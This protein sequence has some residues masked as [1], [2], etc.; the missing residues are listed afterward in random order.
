M[1]VTI[2]DCVSVR[3]RARQ[4]G[5]SPPERIAVLPANFETA[6]SSAQLLYP[7]EA[8]TVKTLFRSNR[9]PLDNLMS[10]SESSRYIHNNDF[11][12]LAPT[13]FVSWGII[14]ENQTFVTV[15]LNVL[16][17]YITEFFRGIPGTR[18]VKFDIVVERNVEGI[19]RKISYQGTPEG[20]RSL[21]EV[22][23]KLCDE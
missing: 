8:A 7:S 12:W 21:P 18:K 16:S 15:A 1:T 3:E 20:I 23:R 9:I 13:L 19:C 10:S 6:V 14:S 2:T 11:E 17:N 4:L 22:I 5:V